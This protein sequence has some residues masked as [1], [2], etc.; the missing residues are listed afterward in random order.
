MYDNLKYVLT[1][2]VGK[3]LLTLSLMAFREI[4]GVEFGLLGRDMV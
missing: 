2:I 1:T 4:V 3:F